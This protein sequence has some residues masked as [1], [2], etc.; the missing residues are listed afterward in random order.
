MMKRFVYFTAICYLIVI[1]LCAAAAHA[2]PSVNV[3]RNRVTIQEAVTDEILTKT[4][5]GV[6]ETKD[7]IFILLKI[8]SNEDIAKICEAYPDMKELTISGEKDLTSIAPVAKLNKLTRLEIKADSVED[9][10]P[11]SSLTG[12][13][14]IKVEVRGMGP[15]LKWMSGLTNLTALSVRA[16]KSLVSFEGVPSASKLT[17]GAFILIQQNTSPMDLTPLTALPAMKTLELNGVNI[18]DLSPLA[19]LSKLEKLNLNESTVKDFSPLAGCPALKELNFYATKGADYNTLGKITRLQVLDGGLTK[20]DDI[21]WISGLTNL[22]KYRMNGEYIKD[23]TPL[24]KLKLEELII[25]DMRVDAI[26][27]GFL[28]GMTGMKKLT[29]QGL[30]G[31]SNLNELQNLTAL[32]TL[33]VIK[34]NTKGGEPVPLDLIKK[35]PN[36]VDFT[37]SRG[38]F[39][40]EQLTGFANPKIKVTTRL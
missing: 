14:N 36:L 26:D 19:G 5:E 27:L 17:S 4:K 18:P 28:S 21:S 22:K 20:L 23:L 34:V 35:L 8:N 1:S 7:L 33:V 38:L 31:V 6:G 3:S 12:L 11:L 16:G 29:L 10:S 2:A 39:T 9:V 30:E 40:E 37:V 25:F 24:A 15:D 32:T 13:T